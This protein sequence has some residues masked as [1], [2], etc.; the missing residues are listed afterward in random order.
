ML[1][2]L[3]DKPVAFF[4]GDE[5]NIYNVDPEKT[6]NIAMITDCIITGETAKSCRD[7]L[8]DSK[9]NVEIT[10]V[11][12]VFI[13][14]PATGINQH[15]QLMKEEIAIYSINDTYTYNLCSEKQED[16]PLYHAYGEKNY[17]RSYKRG[18]EN[19]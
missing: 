12:S 3:L 5:L 16:C 8:R 10:G 7:K 17:E 4:V 11:Y 18:K 15:N 2:L 19:I 6:Y 9:V 13:R 1:H 14:N